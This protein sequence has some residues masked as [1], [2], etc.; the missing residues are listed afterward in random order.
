M[1][2]ET[3]STDLKNGNNYWKDAMVKEMENM[4]VTFHILTNGER[5]SN[6]Y[7]HVIKMEDFRRKACLMMGVNVTQTLEVVPYFSY[8]RETVDIALTMALLCLEFGNADN[9]VI[10]VY[11]LYRLKSRGAYC[12]QELGYEF[13]RPTQTCCQDL[14]SGH[15]ILCCVGD[16]S[17]IHHDPDD[18]LNKSNQYVLLKHGS[19]CSPNM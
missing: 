4:K 6:W 14:I 9:S 5:A 7:Q 16:I 3:I 15:C 19:V 8:P 1:I 2:K 11:A 10:I 12:M 17:C 18:V 13:G